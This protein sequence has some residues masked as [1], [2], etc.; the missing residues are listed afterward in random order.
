MVR[1][2]KKS[3]LKGGVKGSRPKSGG[4]PSNPEW[5]LEDLESLPSLKL[6]WLS[7]RKKLIVGRWSVL[8][9]F[10]WGEGL[11]LGANWLFR[12]FN[13]RCLSEKGGGSLLMLVCC[14]SGR[15]PF[16][17]LN[18]IPF[19]TVTT[20]TCYDGMTELWT[21]TI[22]NKW[23]KWM[24]LMQITEDS[25]VAQLHRCGLPPIPQ[26]H[27]DDSCFLAATG[28]RQ[29]SS[30]LAYPTQSACGFVWVWVCVR[31]YIKESFQQWWTMAINLK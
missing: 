27:F 23:K 6:A 4:S 30:C 2:P 21:A 12:E 8:L 18:K 15:N 20:L 3:H 10:F 25:G 29:L 24:E 28:F 13:G 22:E 5:Q 11:F 14:K 7:T 17:L 19:N 9:F 26:L 1:D 31:F 16:F